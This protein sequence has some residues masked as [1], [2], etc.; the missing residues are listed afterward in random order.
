MDDNMPAV[1]RKA[2]GNTAPYPLRRPRNK[3]APHE[4]PR[5]ALV[6]NVFERNV[7]VDRGNFGSRILV[8]QAGVRD[9][10]DRK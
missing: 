9:V 6:D 8:I 4:R 3:Y 2:M 5:T 1:G 7:I 10:T